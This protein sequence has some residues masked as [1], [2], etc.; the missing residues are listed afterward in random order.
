MIL[1]E[2]NNYFTLIDFNTS[3]FEFEVLKES[4]SIDKI[5]GFF[6]REGS[7][8]IYVYVCDGFIKIVYKNSIWSINDVKNYSFNKGVAKLT[9][10]NKI[11][12]KSEL[13][14]MK[15]DDYKIPWDFTQTEDEDFNFLLWLFNISKSKE[16]QEI[17][18]SSNS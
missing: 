18:I 15:V 5:H 8:N 16:R 10:K 11:N 3:T 4:I 13:I 6:C 7:E 17:M 12:K 2:Y 1:R 9:L 14:I